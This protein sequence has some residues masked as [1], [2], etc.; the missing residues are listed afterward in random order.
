[1]PR[2]GWRRHGARG[3]SFRPQQPDWQ[4][5]IEMW[6]VVDTVLID[7]AKDLRAPSRQRPAA[8]RI[9]GQ[10]QRVRA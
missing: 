6:R 4:Q 5:L 8:A 7:Q 1:M 2:Q 3:P 9:K 10:P